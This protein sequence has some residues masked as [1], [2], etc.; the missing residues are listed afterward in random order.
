MARR[1]PKE[2]PADYDHES[3]VTYSG[4]S[5]QSE[6]YGMNSNTRMPSQ[7]ERSTTTDD[8]SYT[9]DSDGSYTD[10]SYTD[11]ESDS[12]FEWDDVDALHEPNIIEAMK[13]FQG[14]QA[15]QQVMYNSMTVRRKA[16]RQ[17][18]P[19]VDEVTGQTD[20]VAPLEYNPDNA[21]D[22]DGIQMHPIEVP[23]GRT[24]SQFVEAVETKPDVAP[25]QA[26]S[27]RDSI[28]PLS[29]KR[30]ELL[31]IREQLGPTLNVLAP[32]QQASRLKADFDRALE[33]FLHFFKPFRSTLK[34]I[35]SHYGADVFSYFGFVLWIMTTNLLTLGVTFF[36]GMI[37]SLIWHDGN[38]DKATAVLP[39]EN[40]SYRAQDIL[41]TGFKIRKQE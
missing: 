9:D 18:V 31:K 29:Q 19:I 5:S 35:D 2:P 28:V 22:V 7:S 38:A 10:E 20:F 4:L 8:D 32:R 6:N 39:R 24:V 3:S 11:S 25:I 16:G 27:L 41:T 40:V 14:H 36:F 26:S 21:E 34:W 37:P 30:K 15:L 33:N 12:S 13:K 1:Q 17:R 23:L